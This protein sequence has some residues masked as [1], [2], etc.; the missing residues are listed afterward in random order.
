MAKRFGS[1]NAEEDEPE[2]HPM[3]EPQRKSQRREFAD[4]GTGSEA[5]E[6]DEDAPARKRR[7]NVKADVSKAKVGVKRKNKIDVFRDESSE[8]NEPS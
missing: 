3:N 4:L 2:P 5:V 1:P 6:I 8:E 7:K